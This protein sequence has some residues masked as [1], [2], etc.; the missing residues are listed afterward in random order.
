LKALPRFLLKL[1]RVSLVTFEA[2]FQVAPT[3]RV[4]VLTWLLKMV[5]ALKESPER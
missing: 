4:V 5:L 3:V 1:K 2:T